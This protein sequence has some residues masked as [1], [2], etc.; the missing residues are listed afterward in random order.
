MK[1]NELLVQSRNGWFS[2]DQVKALQSNGFEWFVL[3]AFVKQFKYHA[4]IAGGGTMGCHCTVNVHSGNQNGILSQL[5][6]YG[7]L[8]GIPST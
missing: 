1:Y 6:G 7:H 3:D 5:L 2:A 4:S 8:S